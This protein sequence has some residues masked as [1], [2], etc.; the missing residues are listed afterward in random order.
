MSLLAVACRRSLPVLALAGV[1]LAVLPGLA[2]QPKERRKDPLEA[3]FVPTPPLVVQKMLELAGVKKTDVVY[4]LGCGDGRI[5]VTAAKQY[6]CQCY[7]CDIDP[8]R[9]KEALANAKK[10]G[11]L[12]KVTVEQK[13]MFA[14]DLSGASVLTLYVLPA[15]LEKLKPQIAKMKSG[16][17]IVSHDFAFDGVVPEKKIEFLVPGQRDHAVYL[18][19]VP[20]RK[21]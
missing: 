21:K 17:R 4:D 1:V 20:L 15:M 7:G 14:V 13:D 18:Y 11:V 5:L 16:S 3:P 10:N 2:Q 19:T 8:E 9:V 6:G 12:D